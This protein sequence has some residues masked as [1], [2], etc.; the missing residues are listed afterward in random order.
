[1][2]VNRGYKIIEIMLVCHGGTR[3]DTIVTVERKIGRPPGC[4]LH[5]GDCLEV[6]KTMA[7]N[8][9]DSIV[10]D[11]PSGM[12]FM[13]KNW[14]SNRGGRDAW[15]AWMAD[16]ARECLRVI[17]PGGYALVWSA[18]ATSHWTR[19]AWEDAGWIVKGSIAHL[20]GT[21][22]PKSK[23]VA[24]LIDKH[25]GCENRGKAIP[26]ASSCLPSGLDLGSNPVPPYSAKTPEAKPYEGYGTGLKPAR[27]DWVLMQK[28]LSEKTIAANVLRW[29]VGGLNID[30]CRVPTQDRLG[31]GGEK[32]ATSGKFKEGWHHRWMDRDDAKEIFAAKVRNN[33]AYAEA[34][35]RW[36]STLIHDGSDEVLE[37]FAM[38]D[39]KKSCTSA[40]K[41][42][43]TGAILGGSRIEG[44]LPTDA[45]TPARFFQSYS[46]TEDEAIQRFIYEAKASKRDRCGSRHPTVKPVKLIESFVTLITPVGGTILDPFAGTGTTGEAAM[47]KGF[48][49]ILIEQ[50]PEYYQD[51]LRRLAKWL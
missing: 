44:N 45:E 20:F 29:G 11:P 42:R 22:F 49:A 28:P 21:G 13:N 51:C 23:N 33:V 19:M 24:L 1:M 47:N 30:A 2:G 14:D 9:V 35:G 32:A 41:A 34:L 39:E 17:K 15:I 7:D 46:E 50:E 36:P 4:V 8:C 18:D 38:F 6:M 12:S 43:S 40:S 10:T 48:S 5:H 26:T 31:G 37:L 3:N 16:R 25:L 27:E